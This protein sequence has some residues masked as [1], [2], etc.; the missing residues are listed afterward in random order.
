MRKIVDVYSLL[1]GIE[2]L[3]AE[4]VKG[5][6]DIK[7]AILDGPV[8][9]SHHSLTEAKILSLDSHR[10]K[11]VKSTHGTFVSS[12]IFGLHRSGVKGIAPRCSGLVKSIYREDDNGKLLS[13]TQSDIAQGIMSVLQYKPDVI[14]ISGGQR[15][16]DG[17]NIITPLKNAL[18]RCERESVLVVA[19]SGNEGTNTMDVPASYRTVL[20][21]GSIGDDGQPSIF[22]NGSPDSHEQGIMAPGENIIGASPLTNG[23]K[24]VASGTSFST[25]LVSGV[26]GLLLSYQKTLGVT[27]DPLIIRNVLKKSVSP[28]PDTGQFKCM[29]GILAIERAMRLVQELSGRSNTQNKCKCH[30]GKEAAEDKMR[31]SDKTNSLTINKISM[32]HETEVIPSIAEEGDQKVIQEQ[33]VASSIQE[34]DQSSHS[35]GDAMPLES[36]PPLVETVQAKVEPSDIGLSYN[37]ASDPGGYPTFQNSQLINA[38]GQP[39]YNLGTQNNQDTFTALMRTWYEDLPKGKLKDELTDSPH[40]HKSMAAFL[41]YRNSEGY[42]N[43]FMGSQLIW[44]LNMNSTPIYAISPKLADFRSSIYLTLQQFLADNVGIDSS[45]YSDYTL[46][47]SS[48]KKNPNDPLPKGLFV[49]GKDDDDVMRMVL[50]GYI[51]GRTKLINGNFVE[52]VTPVAYGLKDW[53][54]KALVNSL[55]LKGE[56]T[57]KQLISI[58]NRLYVSTLN[59]GQSADDRAL[60]YSLYNILELSNIIGEIT[61]DKLQLSH[62]QVVPSK[63]S[64]Q[65]SIARE[66]RMIFFDPMNTNKASTTYSMQVDVSGVTPVIIG[67]TQKWYAPVSVV[68][69]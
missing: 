61:K 4:T 20:G 16:E 25:A 52:S 2:K 19:A 30:S 36:E 6:P 1:P 23:E 29:T 59:K 45:I 54:A 66:V 35:V 44:L 64:R 63:I 55:N 41:L 3:W 31:P 21:V 26:A 22:S 67:E 47:I 56:E 65:N 57:T 32:N 14:N 51:S 40:D 43:V 34:V 53:T 39:S 24:V 60:N 62:Y 68:S 8:D 42:P 11:G 50:P 12:L 37:P 48:G 5:N 58:L 10:S 27:P 49:E 17:E 13:C 15:L 46:D 69:A 38:I 28:C 33:V 18:D 9:L 7:I